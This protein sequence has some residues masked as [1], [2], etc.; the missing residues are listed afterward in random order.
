MVRK[1]GLLTLPQMT[2]LRGQGHVS[3][4][5]LST[6]DATERP[7]IAIPNGGQCGAAFGLTVFVEGVGALKS[8]QQGHRW[9][10]GPVKGRGVS[11]RQRCRTSRPIGACM[12]FVAIED[13]RKVCGVFPT[14]FDACDGKD[15]R[16]MSDSLVRRTNIVRRTPM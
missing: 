4:K 3:A 9:R 7:D 16:R 14:H 8:L 1:R 15:G 10:C 5:V 6:H 11:P 12:L 13:C 2:Y